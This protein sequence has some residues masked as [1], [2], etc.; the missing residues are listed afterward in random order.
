MKSTS[1]PEISAVSERIYWKNTVSHRIGVFAGRGRLPFAT[2]LFVIA[3]VLCAGA[4]FAQ[5]SQVSG[6]I[7]DTT[8]GGVGSATALLTRTETGDRRLASSNNEGYYSFPLLLPGVYDLAVQKDGFQSQTRKGIK[9]E[10]GQISA[11]DVT[12]SIGEVSQSVDVKR[13]F[14]CCSPTARPCRTW[15]RTRRSWTCR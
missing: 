1:S 6:R 11:V 3:D 8:Q 14:R 5:D 13:P 9:V 10:T 15:W 7:L 2:L 4:L 12:L